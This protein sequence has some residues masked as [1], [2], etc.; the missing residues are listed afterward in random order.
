MHIPRLCTQRRLGLG[1]SKRVGNPWSNSPSLTGT[2]ADS[3]LTE[4]GTAIYGV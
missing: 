1:G 3:S 2:R 4:A